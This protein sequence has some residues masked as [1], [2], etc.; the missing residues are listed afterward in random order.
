MSIYTTKTLWK[1]L[2]PKITAYDTKIIPAMYEDWWI[3]ITIHDNK[4]FWHREEKKKRESKELDLSWF[5]LWYKL[6]PRKVSRWNAEKAWNKLSENQRILALEGIK[7]YII[8]WKKKKTEKEFIPHPATWLDI[9]DQRWNDDLSEVPETA[10]IQT[11]ARAKEEDEEE[12]KNQEEKEA[13]DKKIAYYQKYP[14]KWKEIEQ[15]AL[16]EL[17]E[18]QRQS[19][20]C[21]VLKK[22]K[23]RMIISRI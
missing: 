1:M 11:N 17:S 4:M 7:K 13:L 16:R 19:T 20:M 3:L 2:I 10:I 5:E 14:I 6:Y 15:Q 8:Y 12:K 23:I 18:S 9:N 21:E 22:I